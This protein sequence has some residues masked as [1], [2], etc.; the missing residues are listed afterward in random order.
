VSRSDRARRIVAGAAYSGGGAV[1]LL[2]SAI[3]FLWAQ[4]LIARR[5]VGRPKDVPFE[6][7]GRYDPAE[8]RGGRAVRMV[9]LG[10]SGGAGLGA[11]QPADTPAVIVARG[12]ADATG[13]TVEL[14]NLSVVGARTAGVRPQ[15]EAALELFDGDGPD[16]AVVMIGAN[17]V[18]HQVPARVSVR[19]LTAVVSTLR[20]SGCTVVVACCPDLGTVEPV[21]NPLRA[22]GR[23]LSRTLAAA[24]AMATEAAGGY[25][26]E[27]G[28]LLGPE[29]AAEPG[30]YFSED[31][32]H[33]SS[34]G[35]RRAAEVILPVLLRAVA[36][37]QTW[38]QV[39]LEPPA[40]AD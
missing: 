35:Y 40:T 8:P 2:G 4:S 39:V 27:L 38:T 21:P 25:P 9:M 15:V 33:P 7:D 28:A 17:D 16:V 26:V 36:V 18:T 31:R 13:C 23:R 10:D 14:R 6:V 3:G 37:E 12:L 5:R 22:I 11:A 32:F 24:Q 1:G 29:F 30:A 19:N 34:I 20:E